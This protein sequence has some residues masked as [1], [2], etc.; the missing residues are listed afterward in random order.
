MKKVLL[1][2]DSIRQNYQEYVKKELVE[3]D[4]YYTNDNGRFSSFMLRYLHEWINAISEHGK[5]SFDIIHFNCG[6][7]DVLRLSNDQLPITDINVY[8]ELLE[9]IIMRL[10]YLCPE[11]KLIFATSTSVIEPGFEPGVDIGERRN[12]DIEDYNNAA[13]MVC[14]KMDVWVDDLWS[15]SVNLPESAHSDLVHYETELGIKALGDQVV[16]TIKEYCDL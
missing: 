12:C 14:E 3:A 16:G 6:L 8:T 7:W 5:F 9:R 10:R 13:C 4:V 1:L 2:G 15:V 11:A